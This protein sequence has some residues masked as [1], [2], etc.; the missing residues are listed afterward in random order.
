MFTVIV[1]FLERF[2]CLCFSP[3]SFRL[4]IIMSLK[5]LHINTATFDLLY[6]GLYWISDI[7]ILDKPHHLLQIL[8]K[9]RSIQ[10]FVIQDFFLSC[11]ISYISHVVFTYQVAQW[12]LP[13]V[14]Y[15]SKVINR[16]ILPLNPLINFKLCRLLI[17]LPCLFFIIVNARHIYGKVTLLL[18]KIGQKNRLPAHHQIC[19][20]I[21]KA[22]EALD[23]PIPIAAPT[24]I[25]GELSL[26]GI[27]LPEIFKLP[28]YERL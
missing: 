27:P 19:Y 11:H 22:L 7:N 17:L 21:N 6:P 28:M 20:P 9:H 3:L 13:S 1:K 23:P 4:A 24:L 10:A 2:T 25:S 12:H 15:R 26:V 8:A 16:L 18:T 5:F 14:V